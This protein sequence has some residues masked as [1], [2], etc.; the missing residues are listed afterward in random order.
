MWKWYIMKRI[1]V[2]PQKA[3]TV[4]ELLIVVVLIM[5]IVGAAIAPYIIQQDLLKKQLIINRLQDDVSVALAYLEK[6]IYSSTGGAVVLGGDGLTLGYND[7]GNNPYR[8]VAYFFPDAAYNTTGTSIVRSLRDITVVPNLILS[9]Q[10][11]S[12]DSDA[13]TV[14]VVGGTGTAKPNYVTV[15]I[16]A[17]KGG[18]TVTM[19]TGVAFRAARAN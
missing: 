11:I 10:I 5:V 7:E 15:T 12:I 9:D 13:T 4:P 16:S 14:T 1:K 6:D 19:S 8:G 17:T 3:M 18:E 2:M